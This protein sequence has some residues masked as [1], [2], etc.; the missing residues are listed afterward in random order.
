M[1]LVNEFRL[2]GFLLENPQVVKTATKVQTQITIS[3]MSGE[4]AL[5]FKLLAVGKL[6]SVV[7]QMHKDDKVIFNVQVAEE[8]IGENWKTKLYIT[9]FTVLKQAM[10]KPVKQQAQVAQ[11]VQTAPKVDNQVKQAEVNAMKKDKDEKV[12]TMIFDQFLGTS[13]F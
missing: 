8:K 4:K 10:L 11:N 12:K 13:D 3:V 2:N 5:P 7:A 6:A 1:A 9:N